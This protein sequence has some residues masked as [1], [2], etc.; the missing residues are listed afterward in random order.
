MKKCKFS[1][2]CQHDKMELVICFLN[3]DYPVE[4]C[5]IYGLMEDRE[6]KALK[7]AKEPEEREP[8]VKG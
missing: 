7:K 2:R 6:K 1:E 3:F 4:K 8:L 5:I